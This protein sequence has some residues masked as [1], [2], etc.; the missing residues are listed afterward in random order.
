MKDNPQLG[1]LCLAAVVLGAGVVLAL[2]ALQPWQ[3]SITTEWRCIEA[4]G[5]TMPILIECD[6][7]GRIYSEEE[8]AQLPLRQ[9]FRGLREP[10]EI[11]DCPCGSIVGGPH[12]SDERPAS[13]GDR[14]PATGA[15][16]AG[17]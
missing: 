2:M 5:R 15:Q 16:P 11:R 1:I 6:M 10:F 17:E 7:C 14:T 8:Y 4:E 12:D 13:R 9:I 3:R